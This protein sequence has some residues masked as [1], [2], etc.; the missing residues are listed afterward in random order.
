[1]SHQTLGRMETRGPVFNSRDELRRARG[2]CC[3]TERIN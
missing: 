2:F 3:A 1:M